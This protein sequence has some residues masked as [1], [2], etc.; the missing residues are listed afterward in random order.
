MPMHHNPW[1]LKRWLPLIDWGDVVVA[2]LLLALLVGVVVLAYLRQADSPAYV[3]VLIAAGGALGGALG[4]AWLGGRAATRSALVQVQSEQ[5]RWNRERRERAYIGFLD[6]RNHYVET[7]MEVVKAEE[8][9]PLRKELSA[10]LDV[11][12]PG[13]TLDPDLKD[14]LKREQ[15]A[16]WSRVSAA[17][18]RLQT[19][20]ADVELFGSKAAHEAA[21]SWMAEIEEGHEHLDQAGEY[22]PDEV[23]AVHEYE[24]RTHRDPFRD[25][26]RRELGVDD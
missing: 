19:A 1:V 20:F 22:R 2:P 4:G 26:I 10:A 18:T 9:S 12:E 11:L 15:E 21:R 24:L 14:R 8:K 16:G 25:L 3:P 17:R 13:G 5:R 7:Y 6:A 23:R